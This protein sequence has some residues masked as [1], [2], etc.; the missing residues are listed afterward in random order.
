M[1]WRGVVCGLMVMM[2]MSVGLGQQ[3]GPRFLD[4]SFQRPGARA[5]GMGGAY[6]LAT[7]DATA[8]AWNPAGLVNVKR[9]TLPIEVAGRANF[10]VRDVRDLIDDLK[11]IRDQIPTEIAN[12]ADA[13]QVA[14]AIRAAFNRVRDFS[15][16]TPILSGSLAPVG[17]LSFG[18]FGLSIS[19]DLFFRVQTY[20]GQADPIGLGINY[21]PPDTLHGVGGVVS[22]TSVGI[23]H[24][25]SLPAGLTLGVAVRRVRADF[26]GFRVGASVT[27]GNGDGVPDDFVAGNDIVAGTL[28]NRVDSSRFTLDVGAIWEPPVQ[29]PMVR[30]R[31]AAV[32]RNVLPVRFN[33][34]V[35]VDPG[36]TP[37]L[38]LPPDFNFRL[39][40]EI[41]LGVMAKWRERT[42]LVLELHNVTS[43]NGGGISVHAGVEHWLAGDVFAVRAGYDD[44][45]PVFG[46]GINLKVV[47]I[48]VAA[49]LKP[50]ERLAVG[51]SFRF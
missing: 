1:R 29:P 32:V 6:L 45:R 37:G 51:V 18:N 13:Q 30:L 8:V 17:G 31:Y 47:R 26:L 12:E 9:F 11:T 2:A 16:R 22:L 10:D 28:F 21:T 25:R 19:S 27:D 49:G 14:N 50:R 4:R 46:L 41:D 3:I 23:A 5:L 7:D 48:D 24:A 42:N 38:P 44:D 20:T 40:P 39:N 15:R 35:S 33:L 34:P 36:S 43:S